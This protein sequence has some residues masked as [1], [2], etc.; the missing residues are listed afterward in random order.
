MKFGETPIADAAGGLLVHRQRAGSR[1][2]DKGHALTD[3]DI[4]ALREAGVATVT[5]ARLEANDIG[6]TSPAEIAVSIL[7]QITA[8]LRA[9]RLKSRQA[10]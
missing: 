10:A 8:T 1:M 6:A 5:I 2:L 3:A 7:A 4:E 9:D